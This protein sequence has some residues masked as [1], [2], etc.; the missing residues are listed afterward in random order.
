MPLGRRSEK[1]TAVA[2]CA[3]GLEPGVLLGSHNFAGIDIQRLV[4]VSVGIVFV[5]Q[6]R[7][8]LAVSGPDH[9]KECFAGRI[10]QY[11]SG[12]SSVSSRNPEFA[13]V[14]GGK[15]NPASI[16]G[17]NAVAGIFSEKLRDNAGDENRPDLRD[18]GAWV[19]SADQNLSLVR[20][21]CYPFYPDRFRKSAA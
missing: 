8:A 21:P 9:G 2:Q 3:R 6:K 13:I 1:N 15:R 4:G 18:A 5:A 7:D 20:K 14:I 11:D 12:I 16:G 19:K 10:P 17:W